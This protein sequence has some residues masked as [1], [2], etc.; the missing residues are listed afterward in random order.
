MYLCIYITRYVCTYDVC[1]YY[2]TKSTHTDVCRR[3]SIDCIRRNGA[4]IY[5]YKASMC[6]GTK[7]LIMYLENEMRIAGML[8]KSILKSEE[9][10]MQDCTWKDDR[11][12]LH[13]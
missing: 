10:G 5:V 12:V 8:W 2:V 6:L 7:L 4:C 3:S 9:F 1:M 11:K 13:E